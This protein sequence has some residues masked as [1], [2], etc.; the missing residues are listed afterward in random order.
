M[1]PCGPA[2][3]GWV[4]GIARVNG[5]EHGSRPARQ[6]RLRLAYRLLEKALS[7]Q[8]RWQ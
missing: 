7:S 6:D 5:L 4:A 1:K 8:S 2:F 3:R